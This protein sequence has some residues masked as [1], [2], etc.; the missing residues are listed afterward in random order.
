MQ[1]QFK[2]NKV[3]LQEIEKG[4]RIRQA[5]LPTIRA[6]E[7]ALRNEVKRLKQEMQNNQARLETELARYAVY[8]PLWAEWNQ[9]LLK[10]KNI[11]TKTGKFAGVSFPVFESVTYEPVSFT[12]FNQPLWFL[13]GQVIL[14]RL[15]ENKAALHITTQ[16]IAILEAERKKTT[17]KLNL[18]EKVQ[19]PQHE[20]AIRK[21]K[22]YLEDE[23]HLSKAAQ[24]LIKTKKEM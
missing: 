5:A 24:K 9:N 20:E 17:Q 6:K 14:Q 4:L 7:S 13:H 1:L 8:H 3:S 22:R 2:Y 11:N 19:I 15:I 23:E 10:V 12:F 16:Q 21:I 18:Y